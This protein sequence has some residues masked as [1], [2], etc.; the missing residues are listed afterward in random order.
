[1]AKYLFQASY[2]TDGIRGLKKDGGTSRKAAVEK[3]VSG[4]G[5][6]VE[7][8]YFAIGDDDVLAIVDLPGPESAVAAS[9]TVGATGAAN[10]RT[11]VLLTAEQ[12]DVATGKKVDYQKPGA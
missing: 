6:T 2:T 10:V 1:M 9:M 7:C 5:G 4:L 3:L 12:M 11:T 8:V